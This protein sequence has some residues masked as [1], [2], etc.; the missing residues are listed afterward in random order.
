[1]L[2]IVFGVVRAVSHQISPKDYNV[3]PTHVKLLYIRSGHIARQSKISTEFPLKFLSN[4]RC[5]FTVFKLFQKEVAWVNFTKIKLST[6]CRWF[7]LDLSVGWKSRK[8]SL[9][10]FRVLWTLAFIRESKENLNMIF[11]K[12]YRKSTLHKHFFH[13]NRLNIEIV[14]NYTHLGINFSSNGNFKV[15]KSNLKDKVRRSFFATRRYLDFSKYHPISQITFLSP[16]FQPILPYGSEVWGIYDKDDFTNWA[17]DIEKTHIFLCKRSLGVNK[18][19]PNVAARNVRER[20]IT[21]RPRAPWYSE[22]IKEQKV[23]CRRLERRWRRSR[24]TSDYQFYTDQSTVVKNTIFKS[25]MDYYS[26]LIYP[27]E[28]DSKTL[29]RTITRLLHR[30]AEK[31]FPVSSSAVDLANKFIHF[32]WGENRQYQK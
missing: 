16:F 17:K 20:V 11:E 9:L 5:L 28:S 24:L 2:K 3:S 18:Q 4:K 19:C 23:M 26:S 22:E 14:N 27:A 25:K 10:P 31:L 15:C 29:F 13:I 1:M 32:F 6:I 7:S 21:I 12:K 8:C 30:K